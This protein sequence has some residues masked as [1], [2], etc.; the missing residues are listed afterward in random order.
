VRARKAPGSNHVDDGGA[1]TAVDQLRTQIAPKA[2][3]QK[4]TRRQAAAAHYSVTSG[5]VTIGTINQIAGVFVAV[6]IS[7][8]TIGTFATLSEAVRSFPVG[9]GA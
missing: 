6:D 2:L 7:G 4:L 9:R 1:R 5:R 8:T 3:P